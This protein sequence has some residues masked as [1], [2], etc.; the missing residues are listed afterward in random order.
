MGTISK[1]DSSNVPSGC[2]P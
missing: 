1:I 2:F